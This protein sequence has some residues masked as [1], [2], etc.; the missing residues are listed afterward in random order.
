M[1]E[2][3]AREPDSLRPPFQMMTGLRGFISCVSLS[4]FGPF[5]TPSMYMPM[6]L[7]LSSW[8]RNSR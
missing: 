3:A 6:V 5:L 1:W 2:A 8:P 7:V 4:N